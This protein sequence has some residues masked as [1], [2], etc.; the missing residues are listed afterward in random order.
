MADVLPVVCVLPALSADMKHLQF[1]L[2]AV[3]TFSLAR[4]CSATTIGFD[5]ASDYDSNFYETVNPTHTSWS[6]DNG[7]TLEKSVTNSATVAIYNTTATGGT[8]GSGGTGA[9]ILNNNTFTNFTLQLDFSSPELTIGGD[10]VGFFTK[11]TEATQAGPPPLT[12]SG[13][14]AVFR[15][16]GAGTADFRVWDSDTNPDS[17]TLGTLV[18]T[19]SFTV[20]AGSFSINTFYTFRLAVAT[21]GSNVQFSGSIFTQGGGAQIGNTLTYTD[22]TAAVTGAGEVGLRLG[23][24]S[25]TVTSSYDNFSITPAPEPATVALLGFAGL[26][27]MS[28]RR[29]AS[30]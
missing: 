19:Q 8:G 6:S 16:T 9:A 17:G 28:R 30:K 29:R 7:G 10:S 5:S 2:L 22:T 3:A 12:G 1:S 21:V 18:S 26:G 20:P 11:V 15:L 23:S 25:N 14:L 27:L 24:N 13:Y 4:V